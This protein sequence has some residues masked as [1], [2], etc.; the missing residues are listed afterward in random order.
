MRIRKAKFQIKKIAKDFDLEYN[1]KWFKYKL[2]KKEDYILLNYLLGCPHPDYNKFGKKEEKIR[3]IEKFLNSEEYKK[4][5]Q[6]VGGQVLSNK[7]IKYLEKIN[8][9]LSNKARNN[10]KK[11]L[12]K[13]GKI[14]E[15]LSVITISS[16]KQ[17]IIFLESLLI[18][19]WT[20]TLL[21]K[22]KIER[23]F[24]KNLKGKWEYDEGLTT[25]LTA[26]AQNEINKLNFYA[27]CPDLHYR[28]YYIYA[29]K[30]KNL[31][32]G[33]N[34]SKQRKQAIINFYKSLK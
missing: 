18:H 22:N 1:P 31:L 11:I 15:D 4:L 13:I 23:H 29:L 20:H 17:D 5:S 26:Y 33:K 32:K 14:K 19:E 30:F 9:L 28:K 10:L 16:K 8:N 21:N 7:S 2:V 34:T 24:F 27:T 12:N 6:G 3:N 25:Y